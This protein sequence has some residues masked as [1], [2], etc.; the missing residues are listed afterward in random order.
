MSEQ[1][2]RR[3]FS[4]LESEGGTT[5]ISDTVVSRVVSMAAEEVE[6]VRPGGEASRGANRML[7]RAPGSS[8]T[9]PGVSVQV[10]KTEVAVDLQMGVRYGDDLPDL[11]RKVREKI[12][13][14]IENIVGLAVKEVNVIVTDIIFPDREGEGD[15]RSAAS[16][17][18][19]P[20]STPPQEEAET[21][22]VPSGPPGTRE[23]GVTRTEPISRT[24]TEA[25]SG[26]VPEEEV[27]VSDTPVERDETAEYD[28]ATD[29]VEKRP[30]ASRRGGKDDDKDKPRDDRSG[31]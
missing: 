16:G 23:R 29:K 25:E 14:R 4:P 31:S 18:R 10:G 20:A 24:H 3:A 28:V 2:G 19:S 13:N 1:D 15:E 27:R 7:N 17:R 5:T 12:V 21:E 26:P 30:D 9:A 6:G 22:T 8:G 11:T